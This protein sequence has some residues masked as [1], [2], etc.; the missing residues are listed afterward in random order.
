[1]SAL[2]K[3]ILAGGFLWIACL[4]AFAQSGASVPAGDATLGLNY[5]LRPFDLVRF[6]VFKEPD[7]EQ[8][9]R[10]DADGS[11][12]LPLVGKQTIGGM[13]VEAAQSFLSELY[14][15]DFLVN[16]QINLLV[17][18]HSPR[19]VQVLGQV[20]KQGPIVL[21]IDRELSLIDAISHAGGP[22]RLA[23]L[24]RITLKRRETGARTVTFSLDAQDMMTN[25]DAER[26][27]LQDGDTIFIPERTF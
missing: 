13:T 15:R 20:N 6:S 23:N 7:M 3:F 27:L 16:P 17:V 26:F 4:S 14:D 21:P 10:L 19:Q 5:V 12:L 18:E 24:R 11:V 25:A 8:T 1:M 2:K 22:T 9:F